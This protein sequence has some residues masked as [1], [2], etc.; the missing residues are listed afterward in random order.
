ME[1][2]KIEQLWVL[3][4]AATDTERRLGG[5]LLF[6]F[7]GAGLLFRSSNAFAVRLGWET[8]AQSP[9]SGNSVAVYLI[10]MMVNWDDK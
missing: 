5:H 2:V 4:S 1:Q 3:L 7:E 10:T 8:A 6:S 9:F